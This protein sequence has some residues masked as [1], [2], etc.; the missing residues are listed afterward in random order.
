VSES[1]VVVERH[2]TGV[3]VLTLDRPP[4]NPLSC[5]LLAEIATA[6][7]AL[8]AD[9]E[10]RAVVI[11]GNERAFAAGADVSELADPGRSGLVGPAF[12]RAADA[13]TDISRPVIAAV[14]GYALGGGLE[15]ALACDLRIAGDTARLGVPEILLGIFPGGGGTQRLPRL[16]GPSRAKDLVWSGRQV[17]ADEALSIGLVDRVVPAAELM[18]RALEWAAELAAGPTVA[19]G[20]VKRLVD[21]GLDL[22]LPIALDLEGEAFTEVLTTQDA[23]T[24]LASFLE[25]G[26]GKATF[27]GR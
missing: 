15:I 19:I 24:G 16:V 5:D 26:P 27:A 13:I 12:R 6:A 1:F 14:G 17:R 11:T 20:M 2:P 25:H 3:A 18:D 23:G 4:L 8:A 9:G 7:G 10:V 22:S 21:K